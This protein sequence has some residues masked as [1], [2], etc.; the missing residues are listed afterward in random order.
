M[1]YIG[2]QNLGEK[3]SGQDDNCNCTH[4]ITLHWPIFIYMLCIRLGL[5]PLWFII[6]MDLGGGKRIENES[7]FDFKVDL[8]GD[9]INCFVVLRAKQP[10]K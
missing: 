4:I 9:Q 5:G 8:E 1:C 7:R 3:R 6:V 2:V 10:K